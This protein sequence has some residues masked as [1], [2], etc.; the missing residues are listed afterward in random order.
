MHNSVRQSSCR[1]FERFL[2]EIWLCYHYQALEKKISPPK[3]VVEMTEPE[4]L[5]LFLIYAQQV[6]FKK[7]EGLSSFFI[8]LSETKRFEKSSYFGFACLGDISP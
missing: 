6:D 7:R 8:I 3:S 5:F 1:H 4:V 2:R